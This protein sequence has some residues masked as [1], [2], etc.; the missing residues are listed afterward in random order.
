MRSIQGIICFCIFQTVALFAGPALA[1]QDKADVLA[2]AD[3]ALERICETH[4]NG[5]PAGIGE[6]K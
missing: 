1:N 4:P 2:V 3:K 5:P 6:E